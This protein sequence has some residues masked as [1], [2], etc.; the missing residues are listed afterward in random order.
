MGKHLVYI[1]MLLLG[2]LSMNLQAQKTWAT[3]QVAKTKAFPGEPIRMSIVVYTSTWFT[4]PPE[5]RNLSVP[6]AFVV[7]FKRTISGMRKVGSKQFASLEYTY[8]VFPYASGE[9]KIP[10]F[11]ILIESPPEGD[12]K[13]VES[14]VFTEANMIDVQQVPN[15]WSKQ[16]PWFT[17]QMIYVSDSWSEQGDTLK[18]GELLTR[19]LTI[20]AKGTLPNFIPSIKLESQNG[21]R[22]YQQR[23]QQLDTR[24]NQQANG[25]RIEEWL[26]LFEL[27]GEYSIPGYT[28]HW[29]SPAQRKIM[30]KETNP[31]HIVV[32]PNNELNILQTR[33]DSLSLSSANPSESTKKQGFDWQTFSKWIFGISAG[34]ILFRFGYRFGHFFMREYRRWNTS[35]T[36]NKKRARRALV[37]SSSQGYGLLHELL[38]YSLEYLDYSSEQVNSIIM[39]SMDNSLQ[40]IWR[41]LQQN[42][43]V[44][45]KDISALVHF[46]ESCNTQKESNE[47]I[48]NP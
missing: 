3:V 14:T 21:F 37:H 42:E 33:I 32:I 29:Y 6:N 19:S 8:Q 34:F 4:S 43:H 24:T 46:L 40:N 41:R 9:L 20:N 16:L 30:H 48:L 2:I 26:Y 38:Q 12:Y 28:M 7:P 11:E 23:V 35:E 45:R 5:I 1:F 18:V 36:N 25:K 17:A 44:N 31:R 22:V 47:L 39:D 15:N 27:P 13:G 10:A